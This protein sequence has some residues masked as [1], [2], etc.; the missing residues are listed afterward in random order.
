MPPSSGAGS[1]LRRRSLLLG[2]AGALALGGCGAHGEV[3]D[4]ARPAAR[5]LDLPALPPGTPLQPLGGLV[6][7]DDV[8]GLSGLS[9]LHLSDDLRLTAVSDLAR[10][11][12]AQLV[13][14]EGR[15]AGLAQIRTGRLR[16]GAG[17][18]LPRGFAGDSES[19][20]RLP[21]GSWL[22]GFERWHR[23]RAYRT[24]DAPGT[25][26]EAPP[27]LERAPGNG[28]LEAL[29]VLHDGR[30]LAIAESLRLPGESGLRRAWLG[31]PGAWMSLAYRPSYSFEPCDAAPLPD[32]GALVLERSFSIFSGFRGRLV[33]LSA[34]QL[35]DAEP[36]RVLEG[37]EILSLAPPLPTDNYE[38]VAVARHEGRTL[39]ALVSDDNENMLQR[40]LLLL[41]ALQDD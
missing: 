6:L 23:I 11:M 14:R 25:Y 39:V 15:P 2:A 28:G 27:G 29:A 36:E 33:R 1:F 5:P 30:W 18:P 4:S 3:S 22:V 21:D 12:S 41:F 9:A 8:I 17:R 16:D 40:S 32:G 38:G 19:L 24:L 20:A 26:V 37:E 10:W 35:R 7:D 13:L 31:G 34:A